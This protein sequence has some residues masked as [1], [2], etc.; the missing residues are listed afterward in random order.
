MSTLE[1]TSNPEEIELYNNQPSKEL[2]DLY[3]NT[4]SSYIESKEATPSDPT[5][6]EFEYLHNSKNGEF[7]IYAYKI[8]NWWTSETIKN[9][10]VKKW[11]AKSK[12][13]I[14]I[15]DR[16]ANQYDVNHRF[17]AWEKVYVR[18]PKQEKEDSDTDTMKC[19]WWEYFWIDI[20]EKNENINLKMFT[21]WN[22]KKWDSENQDWRWVSF[23]YI[24]ASDWTRTDI[25]L[26]DHIDKISKYNKNETVINNNEKIAVWFYHRLNWLDSTEQAKH[27]IKL[28]NE[29]KNKCWGNELIPMCDIENWSKKSW[30]MTKKKNESEK[31]NKSRIRTQILTRLTTV[32][33]QTWITPWIYINLDNYKKYIK[34]DDRFKKYETRIAAYDNDNRDNSFAESWEIDSS[35]ISPSIYQS[36]QTWRVEGASNSSW[37]TDMDRT[38]DITKLFSENNKSK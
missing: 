19:K 9:Q 28:Y 34:W 27:F 22:R 21:E 16:H 17:S 14:Q 13:W 38:K 20:S 26:A 25:K 35:G 29:N 31:Q 8:K 7:L 36:R 10:A 32:E 4:L 37:F 33:S 23:V 15:T 24:R 18:I 6:W 2:D 30:W 12:E 1:S 5:P 3:L 11:L